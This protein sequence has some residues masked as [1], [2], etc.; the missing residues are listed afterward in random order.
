MSGMGSH[1]STS[2]TLVVSLRDVNQGF[3]SHLG[4]SGQKTTTF[5][6][7]SLIQCAVEEIII[8]KG[9][10]ALADFLSADKNL[11][12]SASHAVNSDKSS[13]RSGLVG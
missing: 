1:V 10:R 6:R 7:Q 8:N 13:T 12:L 3:W 11:H 2:G 5:S 9:R 4:S